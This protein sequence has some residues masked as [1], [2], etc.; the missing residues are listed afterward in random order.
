MKYLEQKLAL[1]AEKRQA[2]VKLAEYAAKLENYK[3]EI[4]NAN[5]SVN[6]LHA[7]VDA[8]GKII[9]SLTNASL[10]W[11]QMAAYCARM[12]KQKLQQSVKDLTDPE[13]GMSEAERIACYQEQ[14][15]KVEFFNYLCQWKAVNG[16]S[17][18]YLDSAAN[19]QKKAVD[20]LGQSPT[21]DEARRKAPELAKNLEILIQS[22][23]DTSRRLT[24]EMEQRKAELKVVA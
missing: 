5:L 6:S 8:L 7:A 15:F 4:S 3:A 18:Q 11:D 12:S 22:R 24:I 10:F 1:E 2:L 13:L 20:Y 23:M 9:G 21:I 17:Q 19:S 16:L 14:D